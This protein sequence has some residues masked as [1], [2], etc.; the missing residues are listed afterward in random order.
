MWAMNGH[1]V[2]PQKS[3]KHQT[4]LKSKLKVNLEVL[5]ISLNPYEIFLAEPLAGV[6]YVDLSR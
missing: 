6:S 1:I 3:Q 2:Q 5:K 4:A